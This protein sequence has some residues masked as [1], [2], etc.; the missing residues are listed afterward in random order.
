[1]SNVTG[2]ANPQKIKEEA[3]LWLL[4]IEE[5]SPLPPEEVANLRQWVDTSEVHRQ[6][7]VHMSQ[8]WGDM[9]ILSEMMAP[10]TARQWSFW[11]L[12]RTWL[13][14][15]LVA[16][17]LLIIKPVRT[18]P[19][20]GFALACSLAIGVLVTLW[21]LN[22]QNNEPSNRYLT[23]VSE[24]AHYTLADG[25]QLW[26]NS[27]SEVEVIYSDNFRR[28]R[29]LRGEAHFDVKRDTQRPFEVYSNDRLVRALGT[30][31]SVYRSKD[32]IEVFVS[33][34]R[35]E[36]AIVDE[37]LVI[38][39][40]DLPSG[41]A[42]LPAGKVGLPVTREAPAAIKTYVGELA[43][44]Q[45]VSI[46]TKN[47]DAPVEMHSEDIVEH[48]AGEVIRKLSWLDGKLVFAGESL[49]QVVTEI[50]RHTSMRIDVADP[51]LKTMRIGGH[52]QA[53]DTDA[54]FYV[55]ES[56]FGIQVNKLNENHVE[57]QA[58]Q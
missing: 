17:L 41:S 43:A 34:G 37:T 49:E 23:Q 24:Q 48:D 39:P 13:L 11:E 42:A 27:N 20:P 58:K 10:P 16:L 19:Q 18:T 2:F 46:P 33:E 47:G 25:S 22:P 6:V 8:T 3:A 1:M 15:P 14:S 54:L 9:E 44:G 12:L 52:F 50:S 35:V 51:A 26:L 21:A 57:L 56:G 55:L 36:L 38:T 7:I 5:E 4:K 30:A 31:F 40:D 32:S 29:L 28:I 45:S 53:G